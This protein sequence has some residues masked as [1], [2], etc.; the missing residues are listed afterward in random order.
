MY[1]LCTFFSSPNVLL[2]FLFFTLEPLA[3]RATF[4]HW[5]MDD[6]NFVSTRASKEVETMA[7]NQNVVIVA[8]HSGYGKSAIIQHI[9]LQ[10]RKQGW[11]VKP[12]NKVEEIVYA[13]SEEEMLGKKFLFVFNDLIGKESFDEMLFKS[14]QTYEKMLSYYLKSVTCK[15]LISCRKYVLFD[16]RVMGLLNDE[17]F[18]LDISCKEYRLNKNEKRNILDKHTSEMKLS[19]EQCDEIIKCEAYFPLLCKLFSMKA[20][21]KNA[22]IRFFKEPITVLQ[23]EIR[24]FRKKDIKTYCALVLLVPFNN[25]LH[26]E[27][28][29]ENEISNS[30][31]IKALKLC[32]LLE[33]T[34]HFNIGDVL[35]S[36]TGFCY[37]KKWK[38]LSIL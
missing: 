1:L 22:G 12:V 27:S 38:Q 28:L 25:D 16:K 37:Q 19:E 32:S 8:G 33:R 26:V 21:Y 4:D 3:D 13:L 23:E 7:E 36:H 31:F 34:T 10:Y 11:T 29:E 5:E 24:A 35:K 15:I 20:E 14:W 18:I 6:F 9:A 30:K 17:S 2:T